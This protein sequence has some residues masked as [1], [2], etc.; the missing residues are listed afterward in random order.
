[1]SDWVVF[2]WQKRG[3][4]KKLLKRQGGQCALCGQLVARN[5]ANLDHIIPTS[6]GGPDR[7]WNLQAT[8]KRC[9]F[10]RGAEPLTTPAAHQ[11]QARYRIYLA[12]GFAP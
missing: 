2:G 6:Q 9:N 8:H 5:N 7:F 4:L 3:A 11:A 1:M 12:D 10:L